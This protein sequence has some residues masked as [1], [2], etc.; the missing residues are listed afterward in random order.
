MS[1]A[2]ASAPSCT[3]DSTRT[4][5]DGHAQLAVSKAVLEPGSSR[6][7]EFY[8]RGN[9]ISAPVIDTA[10]YEKLLS[11]SWTFGIGD[12]IDADLEVTQKL[13]PI[14][15]WE[16]SRYRVVKVHDVLASPTDQGLF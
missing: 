15:I 7:W 13:N 14:G 8:Y 4:M 10:F 16:N 11:H 12:H 1:A 6:K 3:I 2:I 5:I 9:K